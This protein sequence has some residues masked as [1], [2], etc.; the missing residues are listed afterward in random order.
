MLPI[1]ERSGLHTGVNKAG[2]GLGGKAPGFTIEQIKEEFEKCAAELHVALLVGAHHHRPVRD[3]RDHEC[4]DAT[5]GGG[6][7]AI[8][9]LRVVQVLLE[10][11]RARLL[12]LHGEIPSES[13]NNI[14][15]FQWLEGG[16]Q[17]PIRRRRVLDGSED[18][19]VY[20]KSDQ[21]VIH[22]RNLVSGHPSPVVFTVG[23]VAYR[24][25]RL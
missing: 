7:C 22:L 25:G 8:I 15:G 12:A 20:R 24:L 9:C 6:H 23:K 2:S 3:D 13:T 14:E 17:L 19:G 5:H 16:E 18:A 21:E 4:H 1:R 11:R 10:L